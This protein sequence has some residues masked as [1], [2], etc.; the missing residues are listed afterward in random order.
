MCTI[1]KGII[2]R[3]Q[4]YELSVKRD[5]KI[6]VIQSPQSS[7][8]GPGAISAV[9]NIFTKEVTRD[10]PKNEV[11]VNQGVVDNYTNVE[12]RHSKI[13]ND[14]INHSVYYGGDTGIPDIIKNLMMSQ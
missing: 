8:Y 13:I 2:N 3:H 10:S 5:R 7:L 1:F 12:L 14:D 4:T 6:E 11:Q 9:I